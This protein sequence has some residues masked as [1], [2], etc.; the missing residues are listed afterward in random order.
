MA[1][2]EE[3]L[4]KREKHSKAKHA[5]KSNKVK[6]IVGAVCVFVFLMILLAVWFYT[7]RINLKGGS[8]T[9][10]YGKKYK[11]PGYS[12]KLFGKDYTKKVVVKNKVNEKKLGNYKVLYSVKIGGIT[13]KKSRNVSVVDKEKPKIEL[14]GGKKTDVCPDKEYKEE[15]Y[16][17]YDNYDK[18]L[19][20][21]VK[22]KISKDKII[23][24]VTDSSGNKTEVTRKL[25]YQ[26]KTAPEITLN[27]EETVYVIEGAT[28][29]EEGVKANDNC[30]G[31]VSGGVKTDGS[32]DVNKT[33]EYKINY[34][35]TDKAGNEASKDRT[36]SVL[37][38]NNM[39]A[40]IPG[41]I[42]LTFDDGPNEG[43]TNVILDILKEEGVKATFFVTN[44]GPDY[45][46]KREFDEGHTVALHTA[47][48]NYSLIY[49]SDENYYN[50]L[51]QVQDR[52]K[53]ITGETSMIFR[54]PGGSSNTVSR[55]YS[56]GIM[57]RLTQST[58]AKGYKYYD[59]NISSGDA[60][61]TTQAS[62]VYNNVVS[63]LSK[64]KPN[65][66]LMHDIKTYTR[67]AIRNIIKYGKENGYKFDKIT[68][69]TAMIT[70]K[71]NN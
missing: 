66:V 61:G 63:A 2:K 21:K 58:L 39:N 48:H 50:D 19:T 62:G 33:G 18:D 53:R 34:K 69:S 13:Y 5:K 22:V 8:V 24:S 1:V 31:D 42:Y 15:G 64:D 59:W 65:M 20:K 11:E 10:N 70:Q 47:S 68:M 23:Y 27:G 29:N 41:V 25:T 57:S 30:D 46:I 60:G 56:P 4:D 51:K 40:G 44:N 55:K 49:S 12:V 28:Y 43:T 6:I 35:V 14:T 36:V 17:A 37:K 52:V 3:V 26:D 32:V 16:K 54:F 45:L 71:V 38:K 67:D 7:S 9:V